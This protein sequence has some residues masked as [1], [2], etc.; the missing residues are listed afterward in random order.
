M[1]YV[2]CENET[3]LIVIIS[4]LTFCADMQHGAEGNV[5]KGE[6]PEGQRSVWGVVVVVVGSL[7][8]VQTD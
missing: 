4:E 8:S 3:T 1:C 5:G 7:P 6:E 2:C